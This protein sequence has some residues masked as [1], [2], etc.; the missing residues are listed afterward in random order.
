MTRDIYIVDLSRGIP[1][2][3]TLDP[4][5]ER[6]AVWSPDEKQVLYSS[7]GLNLFTRAANLAGDEREILMDNASKDPYD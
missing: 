2:R 6:S 3:F 1:Q 7:K 4:S 5:E